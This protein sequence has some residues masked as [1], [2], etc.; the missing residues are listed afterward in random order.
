MTDWLENSNNGAGPAPEATVYREDYDALV[1]AVRRRDD[2]QRQVDLAVAHAREDGT[3]WT[4]IGNALGV[5]R[6][7]AYKHYGRRPAHSS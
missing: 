2:A 4:L 3:S 7:A 6:Q 1:Q 5:S